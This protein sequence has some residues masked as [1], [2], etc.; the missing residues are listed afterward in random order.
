MIR[1]VRKDEGGSSRIKDGGSSVL[2][3]KEEEME[4]LYYV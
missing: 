3:I 2:M 4:H 1:I